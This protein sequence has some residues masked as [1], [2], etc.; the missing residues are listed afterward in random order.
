[1]D[2]IV[3]HDVAMTTDDGVMLVA[4]VYRQADAPPRPVLLMRTPYGKEISP[5]IHVIDPAA[6]V[7]AGFVVVIQDVRGRFKSQGVWRPY[8]TDASDGFQAVQWA[9]SLPYANGSVGTYGASYQGAVQLG[10][11]AMRPPALKSMAPTLCWSDPEQGQSFRGGALE[12]GKLLRWTLMNA[13]NRLARRIAD[14]QEAKAMVDQVVHDLAN[15]D[16]DGYRPLPLGEQP[17]LTKYL[18]GCEVFDYMRAADAGDLQ[19]PPLVPAGQ[20]HDVPALWVCGWFDAFL[21]NMMREFRTD[22]ERGLASEMVIGPWSH[23]NQTRKV[24]DLDFG[25]Q[26]GAIGEAQVSIQDTLLRWFTDTLIGG[27][28]TGAPVQVFAMGPHQWRAQSAF[29]AAEAG[30]VTLHL[31]GDGAL[32][33]EPGADHVLEYI[34]DPDDPA[35]LIGGPTVMGGPF[36]P[37][38]RDQ[39]SLSE[40][41]DVLLFQTP[42]LEKAHTLEGWVSAELWVESSAPNT[43]F[44]V[45]LV[46]IDPEGR[47]IGLVDGIARQD[48]APSAGPQS[49]K[50]DLWAT[51][52]TFAA[53][54]RIGV[55]VTSSSFPRWN[56]N[57]NSGEPLISG[58]QIVKAHQ[59][60]HVGAGKPSVIRVGA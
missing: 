31:T 56:R 36:I 48:F 32:A 10:A 7:K 45:R 59:K 27:E 18:P 46:D 54:H 3:D 8:E 6:A 17:L 25:P 2:M 60:L 15:L 12:I 4:S 43:D 49:V 22:R 26:A 19:N 35:P 24:G 39:S 52:Y 23:A 41:P 1:M 58:T 44:V 20:R 57:L 21:G 50:V 40:R 13:P 42:D 55:Q 11:S 28:R 34:Y 9:A 38:P 30:P 33:M 53:G 5:Q 47:Q 37:G 14:P 51:H 29:P 16:T